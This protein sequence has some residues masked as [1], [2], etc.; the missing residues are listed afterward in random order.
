[1]LRPDPQCIAMA[2][3]GAGTRARQKRRA[4]AAV[5]RSR[6]AARR[7]YGEHGARTDRFLG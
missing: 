7:K 1:M 3:G 6:M 5:L 4:V 2:A